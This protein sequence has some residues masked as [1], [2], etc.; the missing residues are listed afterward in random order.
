MLKHIGRSSI[1]DSCGERRKH[2]QKQCG[3]CL[4]RSGLFGIEEVS[5]PTGIEINRGKHNIQ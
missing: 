2:F 3:R 1:D 5:I 4:G